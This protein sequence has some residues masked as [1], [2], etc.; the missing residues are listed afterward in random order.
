MNSFLVYKFICANC[1]SSYIGETCRH[2]KIRIE[3]H[4]KKDN[5]SHI[6]KYLHS[7]ETCF[8]SCRSLCFKITDRANSKFD[9][10]IKEALHNKWRKSKC[11]LKYTTNSFS[12]HPFTIA[13]VPL[14]SVCFCLFFFYCFFYI[15]LSSIVFNISTLIIGTFLLS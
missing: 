5:N 15:S 2:F 6:F 1:S 3:E 11:K 9:F 13:S 8:E 4:I 14:A 12:S 10:N 7:S